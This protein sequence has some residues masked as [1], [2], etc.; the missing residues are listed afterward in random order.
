MIDEFVKF[1]DETR[2]IH[3]VSNKSFDFGKFED[4]TESKDRRR[5]ILKEVNESSLKR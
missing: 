4:N 3:L 2:G 5:I 1:E